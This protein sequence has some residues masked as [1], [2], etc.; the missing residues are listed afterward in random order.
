MENENIAI[1]NL[2]IDA[3]NINIK[4]TY[5]NDI[6]ENLAINA[7]TYKRMYKMW[8]ESAPPRFND[9]FIEIMSSIISL[10]IA[11]GYNKDELDKLSAFFNNSNV[12]KVKI[13]LLYMRERKKLID[14][15]NIY[16]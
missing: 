8:L 7:D 14:T 6:I 1:S 9:S 10:S 4:I 15:E 12:E 5:K 13:F 3:D 16:I 2:E 11:D